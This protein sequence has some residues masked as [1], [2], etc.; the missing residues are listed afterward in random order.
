VFARLGFARAR[1]G[2]ARQPEHDMNHMEHSA[3]ARRA[4]PMKPSDHSGHAGR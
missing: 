1:S 4:E 3:S 2:E